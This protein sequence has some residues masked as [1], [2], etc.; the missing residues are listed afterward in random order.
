MIRQVMMLENAKI[1]FQIGC[2]RKFDVK[3][4]VSETFRMFREIKNISEIF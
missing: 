3:L 4:G 2:L 1:L